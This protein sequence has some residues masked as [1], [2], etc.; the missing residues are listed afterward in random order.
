MPVA[1]VIGRAGSGKTQHCFQAI[2]DSL[3]SA[4]IGDPIYWILPR[5]ATFAAERL[6]TC[7]SSLGGFCR[8]RVLSFDQL[9]HEILAEQGG[10]AIP[11]VTGLGRQMIIGHILRQSQKDLLYFGSVARQAGLATILDA[12]FAE[13]ER[14]GRDPSHLA[15]LEQS[16][17]AL[18]P[19][20]PASNPELATPDLLNASLRDKIH[21]LHLIYSAYS[22]YLGQDRLDPHRRLL[23]VLS[24]LEDSRLFQRATVYIDGFDRFTEY[25]RRMIARLGKTCRHVQVTLQLSPN[26][27]VLREPDLFPDELSLFHPVETAFR[28]LY[29]TLKLEGV[30]VDWPATILLQTYRFHAP[31]LARVEEHLFEGH[32]PQAQQGCCHA[33]MLVE[34][35]DRHAEVDAAARHIRALLAQ[36]LRMR[37]ITLLVRDLD[38]YHWLIDASFGEH[39]IAFFADRRR[40]AAHHPLMQFVRAL[41]LIAQQ[42]YPTNWVLTMLK[43][44][45]SGLDDSAADTLEMY[46]QRYRIRGSQ[47]A[48]PEPWSFHRSPIESA[49][50]AQEE[51]LPSQT[52]SDGDCAE[53]ARRRLIDILY[54]FVK[55]FSGGAA[56]PVRQI[57]T[58]LFRTL[59]RFNVPATLA[60]WMESAV[61]AGFHEQRGEHE[62]IWSEMIALFDELSELLGDQCVDMASF[63]EII[64]AGLEKFDLA[65]TPPTVDQ[66]LVG[67]VDRTIAGN[68][69][70]VLLLGLNDGIFPRPHQEDSI[71]SDAERRELER[72]DV[73]LDEASDR[74]LLDENFLGY[75]AFTRASHSLYVSRCLC[76]ADG[77]PLGPSPFWRR[78]GR[79]FPSLKPRILCRDHYDHPSTIGTPRQLLT[80]V[81]HWAREGQDEA[82][83]QKGEN[84]TPSPALL[85]RG[86]PG[87]TEYPALSSTNDHSAAS[88]ALPFSTPWPAL[89]G[90]LATR[91]DD[92]AISRMLSLA[93][94]ALSYANTASLAPEIAVQLFK[95]PLEA[96]VW[97]FETFA[98]CPFQHF[99]ALGLKLQ[100][101]QEEDVSGLDTSSIYRR[102]M[103]RL[104]VRMLRQ[105]QA[106][107][108]LDNAAQ[109]QWIE[110]FSNEIAQE[111]RGQIMLSNARNR[112]LLERIRKTLADVVASQRAVA[113]RGRFIPAFGRVSFGDASS[114]LGALNVATASGRQVCLK[115]S[116][117]RIDMLPDGSA[118]AIDYKLNAARLPMDAVYYGLNLRLLCHLL[119][120]KDAGNVLT[121]KAL[122]PVA[123]FC[124]HMLRTMQDVD[125]PADAA[126]PEDECYQLKA[127]PRGI[128]DARVIADFD[129]D[130]AQTSGKSAVISVTIKKNG[131]LGAKNSSDAADASEFSALLQHTRRRLGQLADA[132]LEGQAAVHPYMLGR[133]TPCPKCPFLAVCRFEPAVHNNYRF[134]Q[135]LCRQDVLEKVVQ[136]ASADNP[137]GPP[138]DGR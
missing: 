31:E 6:L 126:S 18:P 20:S 5:Q 81:M 10:N 8:A 45:L 125:D 12:T 15:T 103:D 66:V 110:Q 1:F 26:S 134:L 47:W 44:G 54:P 90:F 76:D 107:S 133:H 111:L 116:I 86:E 51:G 104:T 106:W 11:Q 135:P 16:L 59:Q 50:E 75:L 61:A 85:S 80:S 99:L 53:S 74:R 122:T 67:Q 102:V 57:V 97:Q 131:A 3:R 72:R 119:V 100:K 28:R 120:L 13:L 105:G 129:R 55:E 63:I 29:F 132:I 65:L 39:G 123:A 118:V 137:K 112:Y 108:S 14:N 101:P 95:N 9:A 93:W 109:A 36:G 89:Y 94:P 2:V 7:A 83:R 78:L 22:A 87:E 91:T 115:G 77:K 43:S 82:H 46:V 84:E 41:L 25:E 49:T 124:V 113:A 38:D 4:P 114:G 21:D 70:A 121:G 48:S 24:S 117:D 30:V 138:C 130:L 32:H 73:S 136:E 71:F 64:E 56:L 27:P 96:T 68:P 37:D 33:L 128:F 35:P 19:S 34:A 52:I 92:D 42:T 40:Q 127:Q 60:K 79:L 58:A 69:K 98:A 17:L 23:Q 88:S 62:R